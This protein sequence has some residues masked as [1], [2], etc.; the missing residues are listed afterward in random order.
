MASYT[1][2]FLLDVHTHITV[3]VFE[4]KDIKIT[5]HCIVSLP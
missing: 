4:K 1:F 5:I 3:F 2:K